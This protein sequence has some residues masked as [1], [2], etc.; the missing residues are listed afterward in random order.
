MTATKQRLSACS[1]CPW[2]KDGDRTCSFDP[3]T[4]KQSVVEYMEKGQIHPCHSAS[5]FMCSGSLAFA[6]KHLP[7]GVDT[8]NMVRIASRLG[9]F[10]HSLVNKSLNVFSSVRAML[11]DHRKRGKQL[12]IRSK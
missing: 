12:L 1:T 6:E 2:I 4:L 10:D 3:E 8:L 9:I 11:A 7:Y 5:E